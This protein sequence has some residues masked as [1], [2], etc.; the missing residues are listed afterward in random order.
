MEIVAQLLMA[1]TLILMVIGRTPLY[2]TAI[3][4]STIA[5]LAFGIPL[6]AEGEAVSIKSLVTGGLNPVIADMAGVLIFIGAMEHAGF[7]RVLVN[8]IIR[9][10]NKLG[11]GPGVATSGGI[12]AGLIG[13]FTGFTQPAITAVVTGPASVNLGVDPSKS[14]GTHAHAGHLGNFAGFTHPTLL[15]V[16]ATAGI[17]FG[18]INAIGLGTALTIFGVSF[19]RMRADVKHHR[20]MTAEEREQALAE[21]QNKPDDPSVWLV[22]IPFAL[23]V[24]G[25]ALGYP[26]FIV[27]FIVSVIV[28]LMGRLNAMEAEHSML[29]SVKR[30]AVPLIATVGFLYMSGVIKEVGITELLA[31]WFSPALDTAPILTMALVSA[32]AG[33]LTQSNSAS[34][35]IVIP[36]LT[37]VMAQQGINPLAAAAAA[38]GPTAVMQYFLTGGP[39]AALATAIPVVPGS[40]LKTANQFQRPS[41][42]AGLLFV[43]V[44]AVVLGGF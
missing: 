6:V 22:L 29:E 44:V 25:F 17:Q 15:A 26:V 39:V 2:T 32:V 38:A 16:I 21:F 34:A 20:E 19:A 8:A 28:M 43:I 12:A 40:D 13:A 23:L 35:A 24:V 1:L 9:Q 10:G 31:D 14:A 4:G 3:V 42:L 27:G 11:G 36:V 33:L 37:L 30:V 7:L 5:A 41:Q 18:W